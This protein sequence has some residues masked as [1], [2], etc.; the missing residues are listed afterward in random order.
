[1]VSSSGGGGGG[2]DG[3]G[4]GSSSSSSASRQVELQYVTVYEP[5]G[6]TMSNPAAPDEWVAKQLGA[7]SAASF[8]TVVAAKGLVSHTCENTLSVK[9]SRQLRG[10]SKQ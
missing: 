6:G 9:N 7:I 3:G 4:G 1:M 8:C 5:P 2:G 10:M